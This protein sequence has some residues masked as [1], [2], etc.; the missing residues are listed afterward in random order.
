MLFGYI[1]FDQ[2]FSIV[3]SNKLANER[4]YKI[5]QAYILEIIIDQYIDEFGNVRIYYITYIYDKNW[6]SSMVSLS[7]EKVIEQYN[8]T[9]REKQL[10]TLI[11]K[12]LSNNQIAD[13]LFISTHTVKDHL[14]NIFRKL[15]LSSRGE[16]MAKI[17]DE[18]R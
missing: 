7:A 1:I 11:Y 8:L 15:D 5:T 6:F 13:Y 2:A 3:F 12:G 4:I 18:C 9:E 17:F 14:K 10:V 16:L